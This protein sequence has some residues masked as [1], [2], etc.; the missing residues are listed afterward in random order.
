MQ[1]LY[2][3]NTN[4]KINYFDESLKEYKE[5]KK[6]YKN[7]T[8]SLLLHV[9]CGACSCFP[10]IFLIKLFNITIFFSNPNI[11]PKEE[12][13]KRLDALKKYVTKIKEVFNVKIDIIE[14]TYNYD[15]F[16]IFL[17]P[18]KDENEGGNRCKICI[19]K[20]IEKTFIYAQNHNFDYV[21]T[22]MSISRNKDAKY[23]NELGSNLQKKYQNVKYYVS[24]FKKFSGQ[25]IGIELSKKY[26]VYR[27]NYCGCKYCKK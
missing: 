1:C 23:L 22:V 11:Y 17:K 26:N 3:E 20:R 25:D 15:D 12:Y 13:D 2:M 19:A 10:L 14:D 8:P 16:D 7:K 4:T 24:D 5:I 27:Q 9:C 18:L 6:E 21:T